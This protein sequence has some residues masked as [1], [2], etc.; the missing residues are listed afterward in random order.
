MKYKYNVSFPLPDLTAEKLIEIY[1]R[2]GSGAKRSA[3]AWPYI[4]QETLN[5]IKE[6]AEFTQHELILLLRVINSKPFDKS[7]A[8]SKVKLIDSISEFEKFDAEL[9]D[10]SKIY[11]LIDRIKTLVPAEIFF[12]QEWAQMFDDSDYESYE[13]YAKEF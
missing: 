10:S 9:L 11:I 1:G 3:L 5:D 4:R 6:Q 7:I 12:L 13:E 8:C 2:V